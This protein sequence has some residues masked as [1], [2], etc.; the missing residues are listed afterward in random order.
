M[1]L[2]DDAHFPHPVLTAEPV[3]YTTA[4]ITWSLSGK[5][6]INSGAVQL[7][8]EI[9]IGHP[10][11]VTLIADG[12]LALGLQVV[13]LGTYY[14][15]FMPLPG[16][17]NFGVT[18]EAG[19]LL[20]DVSVRPIIYAN[21]K[22]PMPWT[23]VHTE[24]G[25]SPFEIQPGD[26]AGF[27]DEARFFVG[28]EKL[29]PLE[30]IFVLKRNDEMRDPKFALETQGQVVE[31]N[32]SA[33]LFETI[34]AIRGS[35]A[36]DILL[37]SLYT[38]AIMELLAAAHEDPQGDKRWFRVLTTRC[39]YMG[40]QLNGRDLASAAQKLLGNPMGVIRSV[41]ERIQK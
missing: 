2:S 19:Q 21:A 33:E 35:Q 17:G 1:K 18:I 4:T 5:E 10:D 28:L 3:D 38:A 12:A 36:R 13:C 20:G 41:F 40:I 39:E 31:I 6:A 27:G 14:N 15:R 30:S 29:A 34:E 16:L 11:F 25:K 26:V 32:V 23:G 37:P 8:G 9:E 22:T 7:T 24:F